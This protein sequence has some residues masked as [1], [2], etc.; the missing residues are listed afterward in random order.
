MTATKP[1]LEEV[2]GYLGVG[3]LLMLGVFFLI[4]GPTN[5]WI[6][7]EQYAKTNS[8][9]ILFTVPLL[10]IAYV[11]GLLAS[12]AV[13]TLLERLL[14]AILSPELFVS[15]AQRSREPVLSRYLEVERHSRLLYGCT[16]AF[17]VLAVGSLSVRRW[18]P[19]GQEVVGIV[20]FVLGIAVAAAC[21]ILA[22]RLQHQLKLYVN[23]FESQ[24]TDTRDA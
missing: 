11:L 22:R 2:T 10:V 9:A 6:T 23:A 24:S 14:P 21:P 20:C 13:Q 16:L 19:P 18:L 17:L 12:L 3:A 1:S 8:F 5:V 15:A 4:D 7:V